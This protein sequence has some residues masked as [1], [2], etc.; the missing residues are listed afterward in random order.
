[1][2]QA[3]KRGHMTLESPFTIARRAKGM[4]AMIRRIWVAL[5]LALLT[6]VGAVVASAG[7]AGA[8]ADAY[9]NE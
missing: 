2:R 4:T 9:L 1:V 7:P 8:S 6:T 3:Q 5:L